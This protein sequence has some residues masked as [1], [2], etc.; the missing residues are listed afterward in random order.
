MDIKELLPFLVVIAISIIGSIAKKKPQ[1][2]ANPQKKNVFENFLD[3]LNGNDT[4]EVFKQEVETE[5]ENDYYEEDEYESVHVQPIMETV[6]TPETN[7][8]KVWTENPT[9]LLETYHA[10]RDQLTQGKGWKPL[11][12]I[13]LNDKGHRLQ[14]KLDDP[15]EARKA[16]L[17]A[18][19][20]KPRYF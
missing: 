3:E 4:K 13:D 1:K 7:T 10:R 6:E 19:I 20:L 11:E 5:S 8:E 9:S 18:E 15:D 2:G 16:I 12:V 17:Y 14:L